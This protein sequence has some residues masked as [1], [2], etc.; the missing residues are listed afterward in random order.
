VGEP[1]SEPS[2]HDQADEDRQAALPSDA[3]DGV[4]T[5]LG[6]ELESVHEEAAVRREGERGLDHAELPVAGHVGLP[7]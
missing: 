4:E 7:V 5:V 2:W 1:P 3:D 6:R